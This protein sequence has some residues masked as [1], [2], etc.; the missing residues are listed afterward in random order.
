MWCQMSPSLPNVHT[1]HTALKSLLNTS[2][3]SGKL[4]HWG[5][6]IQDL[7]L[8]IH[9]QPGCKNQN[10][11]ALSQETLPFL[12]VPNSTADNYTV[13]LAIVQA[14]GQPTKSREDSLKGQ[15]KNQALLPVILHLESGFLPKYE[16]KDTEIA[17]THLEYMLWT[18]CC[19]T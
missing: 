11:D 3:P 7:D 10:T 17:L 12:R 16:R 19:I 18:K 4:T 1:D 8:H 13:L 2:H 15:Q 6:V 14:E 5:I 9:Y